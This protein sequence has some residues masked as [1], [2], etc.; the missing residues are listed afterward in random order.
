MS[1]GITECELALVGDVAAADVEA[2]Q[3]GGGDVDV[4]R[5]EGVKLLVGDAGY[6]LGL[7]ALEEGGRD[8]GGGHL[9]LVRT[10]TPVVVIVVRGQV[11]LKAQYLLFVL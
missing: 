5:G 8:G 1:A 9:H 11:E 10:G 4:L 3:V 6:L 7:E 2:G